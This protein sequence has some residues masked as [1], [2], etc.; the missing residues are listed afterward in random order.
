M[1]GYGPI[2]WCI[3]KEYHL[4]TLH[5]GSNHA[6]LASRD[7]FWF[8]RGGKLAVSVRKRCEQ[9]TPYDK[10]PIEVPEATLPMDRITPCAPFQVTGLDF[11]G[12]IN[13][14]GQS[15]ED[16]LKKYYVLVF[17]CAVTRLVSFELTSAMD[18][19]QFIMGF[20]TFRATKGKPQNVYS[21]NATTFRSIEKEITLSLNDWEQ[22]K[23]GYTDIH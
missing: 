14:I 23:S 19:E 13:G 15:K 17:T 3:M 9:C 21:D 20:D 6:L 22:I 11:A 4:N 5:G 8:L 7:K 10:K 12:P 18:R 1:P 16:Q 2:A